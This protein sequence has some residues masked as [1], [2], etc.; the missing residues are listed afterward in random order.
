M[1]PVRS[2]LEG[3]VAGAVATGAMSSVMYGARRFGL[4]GRQP[5]T[6]IVRRFLPG[7]GTHRPRP[8]EGGLAVAAHL[9]FGA[10]TGGLFGLL[11]GRRRPTVLTGVGYAMAVWG[12]SYEGW[13]PAMGIQPPAHRDAPHRVG[14]MAAAHV[15]FG[16]TL[17]TAL[18]RMRS[19]EGKRSAPGEARTER[20]S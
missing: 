13:V 15:V 20:G 2:V 12:A 10:A 19:D 7:G 11:T 16:A 4:M 6:L 3:A 9:G 8:G 14:T 1:R 5:P 17:A 18:R